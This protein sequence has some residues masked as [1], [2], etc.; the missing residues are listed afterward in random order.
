[1]LP[2]VDL[3]TARLRFK[4]LRLLVALDDLGSLRRAADEVALTQPGATK[5]LREVESTLHTTLFARSAQGIQPNE[6]GRCVIRYAR[7]ILLNVAHLREEMV[8]ILQEPNDRVAV[9][10]IT[11]AMFGVLMDAL[12]HLRK[13]HPTMIVEVVE[14]ASSG[15]L[16]LLD[17]GRIDFAVC[18]KSVARRPDRYDFVPLRHEP[19]AIIAGPGHALVET[20]TVLLADLLES[21]WVVYP[22]GMLPREMFEEEFREAGLPLPRHMLETASTIATVHLLQRDPT[23]VSITSLQT[24]DFLGEHGLAK[25]LPIAVRTGNEPYGIVSRRG[26]VP[27]KAARLMIDEILRQAGR[28]NDFADASL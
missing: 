11:G 16:T 21:R 12:T 23:L 14:D 27:S 26:T 6:I 1:M 19:L 17:Q 18:R 28:S 22:R 7:L 4:Q 10:T 13:N 25:R 2:D 8:G 24:A 9:G 3:I 5:A 15:L 20:S